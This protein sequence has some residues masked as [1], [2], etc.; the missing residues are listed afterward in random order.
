MGPD[1][2]GLL[3]GQVGDGPAEEGQAL[4]GAAELDQGPAAGVEDRR[5]RGVGPVG[6]GRQPVDLGEEGRV[7]EE[8]AGVRRVVGVRG[9]FV[10]LGDAALAEIPC[11]PGP[12]GLDQERHLRVDAEVLVAVRRRTHQLDRGVDLVPF[13]EVGDGEVVEPL[14]VAHEHPVGLAQH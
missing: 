4:V 12:S 8:E 7:L 11:L 2:R 9:A 10:A 1:A 5:L 3:R 6:Q 13:G 14:L